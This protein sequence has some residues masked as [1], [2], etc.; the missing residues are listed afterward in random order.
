MTCALDVGVGCVPAC[1]LAWGV[2]PQHSMTCTHTEHMSQACW[3][4][5]YSAWAS[6]PE[7]AAKAVLPARW[8]D[9]LAAH[10]QR[11]K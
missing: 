10:A 3:A 9:K 1:A 2:A 6:S 8:L 11:A 5:R 7:R 4:T